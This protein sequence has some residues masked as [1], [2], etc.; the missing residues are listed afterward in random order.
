MA[1]ATVAVLVGSELEGQY[2]PRIAASLVPLA[3]RALD[4]RIVPLSVRDLDPRSAPTHEWFACREAIDDAE[5]I[6]LVTSE[7]SP[8]VLEDSPSPRAALQLDS[9]WD[10]KPV[11][12]IS[13]NP[14]IAG[15]GFAAIHHL[16]RSLVFMN[17]PRA[18]RSEVQL[19]ATANLFDQRGKPTNHQARDFLGAFLVAFS[20]WITAHRSH[21]LGARAHPDLG[22][23]VAA[24]RNEMW[25]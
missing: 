23:L 4:L 19:G 2:N 11:A 20:A 10:E 24:G 9:A 16:K 22:H 25:S 3:P 12:V 14:R 15:G 21:R 7:L 5:A 13:A 18:Q 6:L 1:A 17:V 8:S